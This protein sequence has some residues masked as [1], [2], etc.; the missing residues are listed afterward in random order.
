MAGGKRALSL[1]RGGP[2]TEL[3]PHE[4]AGKNIDDKNDKSGACDI[5]PNEWYQWHSEVTIKLEKVR[6]DNKKINDDI[7]RRQARYMRREQDY[8]CDITGL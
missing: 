2:K 8:R 7:M 6:E 4:T 5:T 3:Y 1:G